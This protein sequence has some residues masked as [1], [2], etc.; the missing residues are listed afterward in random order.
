MRRVDLSELWEEVAVAGQRARLASRRL[1]EV[2]SHYPHAI[3]EH[4]VVEQG[5]GAVEDHDVDSSVS[6]NF[7][8]YAIVA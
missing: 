5:R 1:G 7:I 6:Y 8:R 2:A 3:A 4:S